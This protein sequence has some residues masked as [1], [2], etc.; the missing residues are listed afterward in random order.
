MT[1]PQGAY[2][3][4]NPLLEETPE[5]SI[6]RHCTCLAI[7]QLQAAPQNGPLLFWLWS[8]PRGQKQQ[9]GLVNL[10]VS[11]LLTISWQ[12]NEF[13]SSR[14]RK[15]AP[16][17]AYWGHLE[18]C[19]R[20]VLGSMFIVHSSWSQYLKFVLKPEE[21]TSF[22]CV[23]LVSPHSF[24]PFL[25]HLSDSMWLCPVTMSCLLCNGSEVCDSHQTH[26]QNPCLEYKK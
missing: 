11:N 25:L 13:L 4:Q 3:L 26:I 19:Q 23:S 24:H 10:M 18:P 17:S 22:D 5:N 6:F 15:L 20:G 7:F 9:T 21:W 8:H 1:I 16:G 12:Q 14:G 2:S